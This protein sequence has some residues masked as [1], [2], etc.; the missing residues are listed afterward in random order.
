MTTVNLTQTHHRSFTHDA[1]TYINQ[2]AFDQAMDNWIEIIGHDDT[3]VASIYD[4]SSD[5]TYA[6]AWRNGEGVVQVIIIQFE[7]DAGGYPVDGLPFFLDIQH[8]EPEPPAPV[9][10]QFFMASITSS[11]ELFPVDL[12]HALTT[13]DP[14][15]ELDIRK[16]F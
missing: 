3:D 1:R 11:K 2:D 9:V 16:A 7:E 14:N 8:T 5:V 4:G 15:A 6:Y 10:Q 12:R 13:L